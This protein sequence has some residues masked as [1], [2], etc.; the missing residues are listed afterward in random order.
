MSEITLEELRLSCSTCAAC[1]LAERRRTVVFGEGNPNAPLVLVGEGPGDEEDR[2][3]RPFVGRSGQMLDRA[4]ADNGLTRD[5][6]FICNTVKCRAADWST[7]K[8]RNRPPTPLEVQTCRQW[9]IP[10]LALL[11]AE[12]VLC[13]GAP[14]AKNLIRRDFK[15]TVERGRLFQSD[16]AEAILATLH[17][18][19]VMRNQRANSDGGY[20]LIVAD[21][22]RA[23]D[24]ARRLRDRSITTLGKS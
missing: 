23:W 5:D 11:R 24:V 21:I 14:S 2:T 19:Y 15:I 20:S 9:L 18:A 16:L 8:P 7:G 13:I 17:P 3:G 4:L 22:G 12:V 1:S 6:V 10:Q